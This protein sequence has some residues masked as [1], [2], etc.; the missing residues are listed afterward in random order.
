MQGSVGQ[1]LQRMVTLK[2]TWVPS[3][4]SQIDDTEV[5]PPQG[6]A[7]VTV[8]IPWENELDS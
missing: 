1:A 4:E 6:A 7:P 5:S 3:S 2:L 8:I